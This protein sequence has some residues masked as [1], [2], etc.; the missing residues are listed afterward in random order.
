MT[1]LETMQPTHNSRYNVDYGASLRRKKLLSISETKINMHR[2]INSPGTQ[3]FESDSSEVVS[4]NS[5]NTRVSSPTVSS[6]SRESE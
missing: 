4:V 6:S 3:S 5:F 1:R 2:T